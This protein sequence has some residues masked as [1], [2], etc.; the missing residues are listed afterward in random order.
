MDTPIASPVPAE[1]DDTYNT[2]MLLNN[3]DLFYLKHNLENTKLTPKIIIDIFCQIP[4]MNISVS[5]RPGRRI[6][7]RKSVV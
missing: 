2:S 4:D 7:D 3:Y 1:L 6:E 5:V